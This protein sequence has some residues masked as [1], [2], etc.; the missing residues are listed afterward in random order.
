M[1]T[2]IEEV[3]YEAP[4]VWMSV[5]ESVVITALIPAIG[6]LFNPQDP[7]FYDS[8]FA[9]LIAAPLLAGLRYGFI[10]GFAS[11]LATIAF[12]ALAPRMGW[13]DTA[14][15]VQYAIGLVLTGMVSGEFTDIWRRRFT[16][17]KIINEYQATRLAEFV[18]NYH[19]LRVSHDQLAE[20]L[21]AN[22]HNLRDAL[23]ALAERF[24]DADPVEDVLTQHSS[25]LLS[26]MAAEG[27]VEQCALYRVD[28][29]HCV[30]RQPIDFIGGQARHTDV[31]GHPMVRACIEQGCMISLKSEMAEDSPQQTS[32]PMLA[33][34]PLID[35]NDRIWAV[36]TVTEMPFVDFERGN[37]HLLAVLGGNLGDVIAE[38]YERAPT[39]HAL[40]RYRFEERLKR[41]ARYGARYRLSSLLMAYEIPGRI[42]GISNEALTDVVYE[43]LRALDFAWTTDAGD[44]TQ[45]IYVLMPLTPERGAAAYRERMSRMLNERFGV[46]VANSG[47][48]FHQRHVTGKQSASVLLADIRRQAEN[49][50]S[51]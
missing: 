27:R 10:Y 23:L 34:I 11:A 1:V 19:V 9:W 33:V 13:I 49:H 7:L 42:R 16:Q 43:Q 41:W 12:M 5:L 15:P 37:L 48:V 50:A 30:E 44:D 32:H 39:D 46:D 4:P 18:R 22:P 21:A 36:V 29:K 38:G 31:A 24:H 35:V 20:R 51:V 45:I 14:L 28:E 40:A 25:D 2:Q 3:N 47:L 8:P 26:F 17:M 6:W